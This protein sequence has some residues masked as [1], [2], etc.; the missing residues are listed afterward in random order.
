MIS[1]CATCTGKTN[2]VE[3]YADTGACIYLPIT[4]YKIL[5]RKRN[6]KELEEI[7]KQWDSSPHLMSGE[8][9]I[10]HI[11]NDL[12]VESNKDFPNNFVKAVQKASEVYDYVLLDDTPQVYKVLR[13][14]KI[15]F[16]RILPEKRA[17][18]AWIGR[19]YLKGMKKI[20]I[21][22][23]IENWDFQYRVGADVSTFYLC[24]DEY[25]SLQL[26]EKIKTILQWGVKNEVN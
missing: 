11:K 7:R 5:K 18:D 3:K 23:V 12:I 9:Y 6:K 19:M 20:Y 25:L 4:D 22:R 1:C 16:I 2:F 26:F 17:R 21:D 14:S 8:G 13:D 24:D 10:N 15:E